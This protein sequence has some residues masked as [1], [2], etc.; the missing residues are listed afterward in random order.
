[1]E[2]SKTNS[3][4][5]V[6]PL[7]LYRSKIGLNEEERDVLIKEIYSHETQSKN[8]SYKNENSSW[9]GD[10]QGFEFLFLNK[11][12]FKLFE[13]IST[14][15]KEYTKVIGINPDQLDFYYQRSW[16]TI[17]RNKE[18]IKP[19]QHRQSH[20]SFAYYL[21]KDHNSGKIAFHNDNPRNEIAPGMFASL[22]LK[23]VII[24]NTYNA[25]SI[26][27]DTAVDDIIIFPSKTLHSVFPAITTTED[28]IS[29][30]ADVSVIAKNSENVETLLTPIDKWVKF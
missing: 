14:K 15:I 23:K 7:T 30:S 21:K 24:P 16:A 18:G 4:L 8:R 29:I 25:S 6:F 2:Q 9:T 5:N 12:F 28:R 13:L 26:T 10:T 20:I 3:V 19:H 22:T 11:K 1:M 27:V 17:S